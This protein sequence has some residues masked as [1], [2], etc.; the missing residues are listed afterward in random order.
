MGT[1]R[2]LP[3]MVGLLVILAGFPLA[4]PRPVAAAS[5]ELFFS[6]YIEGS[7]NNKALEIFNDTGAAV[8]LAAGGYSV[9]MHF[10]GTRSQP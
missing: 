5:T 1:R 9:T 4:T 6:E 8:N 2:V 7:S 3:T 10:N